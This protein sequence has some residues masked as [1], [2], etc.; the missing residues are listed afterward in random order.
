MEVPVL[1]PKVFNHPFTYL[2][3][4][5]NIG[6]LKQGDLVLVPFGSKK[7]I[8]VV[9]DEIRSTK[10]KIKL[11]AVEKKISSIC[12]DKRMIR[13]IN[14]FST[15]KYSLQLQFFHH[16]REIHNYHYVVIDN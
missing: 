12:L 10:K 1:L 8:G 2:N 4:S 15:Y 14:W 7:E 6:G 11:K 3:N 5:Q 16:Q 9:W 13:F